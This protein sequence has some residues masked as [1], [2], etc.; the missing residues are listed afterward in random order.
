MRKK[1]MQAKVEETILAS[2][3]SMYR[4]AYA[5]IHNRE[6]ALDIVQESAYKAMKHAADIKQEEYMKT[7]YG[8][9]S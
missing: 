1:T 7:G 5:H 3:E 4:L 2:Y 9:S 6:D 8:G